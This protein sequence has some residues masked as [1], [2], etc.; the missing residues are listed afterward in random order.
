MTSMQDELRARMEA[1]GDVGLRTFLDETLNLVDI[2]ARRSAELAKS[3]KLTPAGIAEDVRNFAATKIAPKI[4]ETRKMVQENRAKLDDLRKKLGRPEIDPADALAAEHRKEARAVLR[5]MK[6]GEQLK[7]LMGD[8]ADP[9]FIAAALELDS[10]ALSGVNAKTRTELRQ[11][12]AERHHPERLAQI[13]AREEALTVLDSAAQIAAHQ[14]RNHV[15]LP[16]HQFKA[17][18]ET[19]GKAA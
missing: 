2:P 9:V 14:L 7:L 13:A 17:W 1:S 10:D 6:A 15:G 12:Y 5:G 11:Q 3:G 4:R 8:G 19:A 18:L 16:D